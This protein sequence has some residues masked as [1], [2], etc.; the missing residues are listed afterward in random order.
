MVRVRGFAAVSPLAK[1]MERLGQALAGDAYPRRILWFESQSKEKEKGL[2]K[3]SFFIVLRCLPTLKKR[4]PFGCLLFGGPEEIRTPDPYNANVMRSQLRYG[5]VCFVLYAVWGG[6]SRIKCDR[7]T[8]RGLPQN[9][10]KM[11]KFFVSFFRN[12]RLK[13][14]FAV[15]YNTKC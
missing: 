12:I 5:P 9:A 3:Q 4:H 1:H 7:E 15:W 10:R 14:R 2:R 13:R 8:W 6:L 11:R